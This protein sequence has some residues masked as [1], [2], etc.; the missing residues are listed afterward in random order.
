MTTKETN[1]S[2]EDQNS[3]QKNLKQLNSSTFSSTFSSFL[4][5]INDMNNHHIE[6]ASSYQ[7]LEKLLLKE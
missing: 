2:C 7:E 1:P 6:S 5:A 4:E 3:K